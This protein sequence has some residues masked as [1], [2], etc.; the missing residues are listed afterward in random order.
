MQTKSGFSLRYFLFLFLFSLFG[1]AF[2]QAD[3]NCVSFTP[4]IR[5]NFDKS[6]RAVKFDESLLLINQTRKENTTCCQ[7]IAS[8]MEA[9]LYNAQGKPTETFEAAKKA[10]QLL[11]GQYHPFASIESVR[12][13]AMHY[14]RIGNSDSAA[15]LYFKSLDMAIKEKQYN[16]QAKI[17]GNIIGIY[18]NQK[19][20][21][22]GLEYAK[23]SLGAAE[24]AKDT[25]TIAQAY[26]N[27][28]TAY[29]NLYEEKEHKPYVDSAQD[30]A[31]TALRYAKYVHHP[32][33]M[34][35][36]YLSLEKFA[37][38]R[39][40][41][42]LTLRY[43]D[44]CLLLVNEKENPAPLYSIYMDR[45]MAF[46]GLKQYPKA[47]ECFQKT[48]AFSISSKN[49][50]MNKLSNERLYE[51]YKANGQTA[52]SLQALEKY[53]D[54]SDSLLTKQN[55]EAINEMEQ[56]YNKAQNEKKIAELAYQKRVYLLLALAGLLALVGLV[57]FI[58]QQS[59]KSK[60]KI[61]E[62]EQRL[63]RA[64]MNP[65]FFFNA[66]ASLQSFALQG[67]DGKAMAS[68]LSKFS[69]I[70]RE[71]LE[72]TYKEYVTLEQEK[73][74]LEEY[75]SL[76]ATRFPQQFSFAV[77][78]DESIEPDETLL[79]SMIL[80]PFVENSIEHGFMGIDYTGVVTITFTKE[81]KDLLVRI[82]DN[83]KGLANAP[84]AN[85]EHISRA[86]Q[87]IKDRIYLLNVKLKSRASFSIDNNVDGKGVT[88]SIK[89]PLLFKKDIKEV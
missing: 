57:F 30:I 60:Q 62:T 46:L 24:Q 39:E 47:I 34:V 21:G 75:L 17:Y 11:K 20:Y 67:N 70:M 52:L 9:I 3:C 79:P 85:G 15:I 23:K 1:N 31:V 14:N 84:T 59:L 29:G 4:A 18:F 74:F 27:L 8:S 40:D 63:N 16:V 65:H 44:S 76:Q 88:V 56:K 53:K 38:L 68:S 61:L 12:L 25:G 86:S 87:I 42:A 55:A 77:L 49:K 58:R 82:T 48:E 73:E 80:Q 35:R 50:Y 5:A 66:L 45:G 13:I 2:G 81:A 51:A 71:T 41:F 83:G 78:L 33:L 19:Q 37:L 54:L 69:H 7:A 28:V 10:E 22:K 6:I 89:L 36:N 26:A 32:L 64:R 72:S 43:T